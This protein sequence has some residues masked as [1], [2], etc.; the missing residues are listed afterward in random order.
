MAYVIKPG[1]IT[2]LYVYVMLLLL[3]F[4]FVSMSALI[5]RMS[6]CAFMSLPDTFLFLIII[7]V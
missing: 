5:D 4:S 1:S 7:V 6:C 3:I 2:Q